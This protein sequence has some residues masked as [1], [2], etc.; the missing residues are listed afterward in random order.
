MSALFRK[1]GRRKGGKDGNRE[2]EIR[3]GSNGQMQRNSI[4][5]DTVESDI[6]RWMDL[7]SVTQSGVS[8]KEKNKCHI[9]MHVCGI[10]KNGTGETVSR[11]GI[12]HTQMECIWGW[13]KLGG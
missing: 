6:V 4:K 1:E 10:Q 9:L 7:E 5:R 13:D 2:V 11:A 3:E 8:L 12:E